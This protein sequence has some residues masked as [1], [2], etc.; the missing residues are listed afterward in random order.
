[1]AP[2]I[3]HLAE[4]LAAVDAVT[5]ILVVIS[6]GRPF[7]IDYGQQYG[8]EAILDYTVAD[9]AKALDEARAEGIHPYLVTVDPEGEDYL[10]RAC[11]PRSYHVIGE[12]AELPQALADLYVSVRH[13]ATAG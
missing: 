4:R 5:K 13:E 12:T 11:D 6:D 3:R 8:D 2:A 10:S 1:M 9:T 7:D